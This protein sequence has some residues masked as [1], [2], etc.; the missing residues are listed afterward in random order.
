MII[1]SLKNTQRIETLHPLFPKAFHYI[2]NTDFSN[3]PDGIYEI[4]GK[5]LTA[6]IQ[7]LD[8]KKK[9]EACIEKHDRFIDIQFPL[10]GVE[11]MGWKA[12]CELKETSIPYDKDKD[13]AFYIDRPTTFFKIYPGQCAIFFPEDGHAPGIGEGLIRKVVVKVRVD[14]S[15]ASEVSHIA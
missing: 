1:E 10:L 5:D 15:D 13:I 2:L 9:K 4:D 3:L 11:K 14:A 7:H 6:S 8:C 12:G